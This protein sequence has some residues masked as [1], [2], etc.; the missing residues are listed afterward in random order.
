MFSFLRS[1]HNFSLSSSWFPPL[2]SVKSGHDA[3]FQVAMNYSH[4]PL[5]EWQFLNTCFYYRFL[6]NFALGI[7]VCLLYDKECIL[8]SNICLA[9]CG[10]CVV[11]HMCNLSNSR[12]TDWEYPCLRLD[13]AKTKTNKQNYLKNK[14]KSKNGGVAQVIEWL[15]SKCKT[16][17]SNK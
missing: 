7:L 13:Q 16:L 10:L 6:V 15:P 14:L 9:I 3:V 12:G 11:A 1:L 17:S 8:W 5:G 4:L 2:D